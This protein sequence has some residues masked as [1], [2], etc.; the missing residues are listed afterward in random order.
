MTAIR[1]TCRFANASACNW[2]LRTNARAAGKPRKM[3]ACCA[4]T[5]AVGRSSACSPGF[6]IFVAWSSA[7]N[8]TQK[9]SQG[10]LEDS[11]GLSEFPHDRIR[12]AGPPANFIELAALL[13]RNLAFSCQLLPALRGF[14]YAPYAF[15]QGRY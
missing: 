7:G 4:A 6:I 3:A 9:I 12:L 13:L 11:R 14:Q 1:W 5:V 8:T 10:K 2:W 15:A